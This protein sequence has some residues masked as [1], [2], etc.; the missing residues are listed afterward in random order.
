MQ[1]N[2]TREERFRIRQSSDYSPFGVQLSGRNL[3]KN[4]P[5]TGLPIND[6]RYGFQGQEE[7]DEVSGDGNSY[8]AEFWQYDSRL[9]RRW[10]ID[11]IVKY[12]ESPYACFANNPISF[13]DPNGADTAKVESTMI[14]AGGKGQ[15]SYLMGSTSFS[16]LFNSFVNGTNKDIHLVFEGVKNLTTSEPNPE[17]SDCEIA[18]ETILYYRNKAVMSMTEKEREL[19]KDAKLTDFSI[20]IRMNTDPDFGG[21]E[22]VN[23][24]YRKLYAG[25][26]LVHE[27]SIHAEKLAEIMNNAKDANGNFS[28]NL[29]YT[30]YMS[31]FNSG[32]D[33]DQFHGPK[34][35][36]TWLNIRDEVLN[37]NDA[38]STGFRLNHKPE[39][40]KY[41]TPGSQ[42]TVYQLYQLFFEYDSNPPK[43]STQ[44]IS[45]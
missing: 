6:G 10:N 29:L 15:I 1:H 43:I 22:G 36:T 20:R 32:A 41:Y 11:P 26:T 21:Q 9:G 30:N 17:C 34:K 31:N 45:K 37:F 44:Q 2:L 5:N 19:L 12:H 33:H 25:I 7:D 23:K 14:S 27:L 24:Y 38:N 40:L 39:I 3:T 42:M 18:A 4:N 28:G 8:T 16:N 13:T 35:Q